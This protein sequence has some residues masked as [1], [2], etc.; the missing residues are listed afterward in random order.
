MHP[1]P[2]SV[3]WP[4]CGDFLDSNNG[5]FPPQTLYYASLLGSLKLVSGI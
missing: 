3:V 5:P 4:L 1:R 2:L